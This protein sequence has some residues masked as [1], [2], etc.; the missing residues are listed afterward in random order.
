MELNTPCCWVS[1]HT[2]VEICWNWRWL[3]SSRCC[4][5]EW[6]S[7]SICIAVGIN[8]INYDGRIPRCW[9]YSSSYNWLW[10]LSSSF[11]SCLC[12]RMCYNWNIKN[13]ST[14]VH[15][16]WCILL[17][18]L[19]FNSLE[20]CWVIKWFYNIII[21][22]KWSLI[23]TYYFDCWGMNSEWSGNSIH[24]CGCSSICKEL[25]HCPFHSHQTLD[26]ISWLNFKLTCSV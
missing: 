17:S 7:G 6:R 20:S 23:D 19:I 18:L 4:T 8:S 12:W 3:L 13:W 16:T 5:L 9:D 22:N 15:I 1:C 2:S 21:D 10:L 14:K 26:C 25:S 11:S 24:E